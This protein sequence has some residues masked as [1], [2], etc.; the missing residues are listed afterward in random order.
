MK[1]Q[2]SILAGKMAGTASRAIGRGGSNIPGV[3]A[4][5]V[6]TGVLRALAGQVEN[7]ILVSGTN[8]KTTTSQLLASILR[9]GGKSVVH[10][11]EGAN[12]ITGI[13]SCFVEA[14]TLTGKVKYDYAVVE[15]DE[16]TI[17]KVTKEIQ[18]KAIVFTNF[19]R[20]QLDRF[21]EIDI[22]LERIMDDLKP[23]DIKMILNADDPFTHRLSALKKETVYYGMHKNAFVFDQ[24]E[25]T[26]SKFCPGCGKEMMYDHIHYGQLGY[27][28]CSCGFNRPTPTYELSDLTSD[29]NISFKMDNE[30]YELSIGGTFNAGNALAAL[31]A[32]RE[33]GIDEES[34]KRGLN[35]YVSENGR[36]QSFNINGK[37]QMLN[38]VKNPAGVNLTISEVL[39]AKKEQQIVLFLNDL[40]YD[41]RDVS[42][43]WDADY[44][45]L[46]REDVVRII[47]SGMRANDLAV[48]MKYAGVDPGKIQVIEK[49]EEAIDR[50]IA[51]NIDT[52]FIPNYTALEPVRK[53]LSQK[54][55]P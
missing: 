52:Y 7:I 38:L 17:S 1:K 31:A 14:A 40:D 23:L 19:F 42:W 34:I 20:D 32:A 35:A 11:A 3:V 48:R 13:T 5:K 12:L 47:C 2:L 45:R 50:A 22:L 39:Y 18:P 25:M 37:S 55:K 46:N 10:N 28:R 27:Y 43:I 6:D 29:G 54:S 30:V 49:K 51:N 9:A 41:G 44:E 24:H 21:G 53:Y 36:M 8:G 26:E 4:R 33:F 15:T 16:A